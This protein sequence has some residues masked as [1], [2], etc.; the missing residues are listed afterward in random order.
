VV[1]NPDRQS[2]NLRVVSAAVGHFDYTRHFS[3]L[4]GLS[5]TLGVVNQLHPP[6]NISAAFASYGALHAT[7]LVLASKADLSIGRRLL[8]IAASAVLCLMTLRMGILAGHIVGA[9]PGTLPLYEVFGFSAALGAVT[10]GI[11]IRL[12]GL[13]PLT[14]ITLTA[15]TLG[16]TS[17]SFVA[18]FTER[19]FH[20][21]GS[22]WIAVLWWYAFSLGLWRAD[23]NQEL[24]G[25]RT[26]SGRTPSPRN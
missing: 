13:L 25:E 21:L 1:G 22:W 17:A 26:C 12:F 11:L 19:Y 15:L 2:A 14:G 24:S 7:A 9:G 3:L 23:R 20:S 6:A 18:L 16:C 10:Y 4:T 5:L 8:F